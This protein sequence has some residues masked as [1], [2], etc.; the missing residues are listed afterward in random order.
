MSRKGKTEK[1]E[2]LKFCN[3]YCHGETGPSRPQSTQSARS[4][5]WAGPQPWLKWKVFF[6]Y[7]HDE[8][9][10]NPTGSKR[11]SQ[12][13]LQQPGHISQE[14][15]LHLKL[16]IINV[17]NSQAC[18]RVPMRQSRGTYEWNNLSQP[19]YLKNFQ[20]NQFHSSDSIFLS[21]LKCLGYSL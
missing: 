11:H 20:E 1:R 14:L 3:D 15:S 16:I 2:R 8:A 5:V 13:T 10:P 9:W 6:N 7:R 12:I 17:S 18:H 21:P 4:R 19:N